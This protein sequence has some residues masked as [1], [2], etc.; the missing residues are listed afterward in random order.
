MIKA[1]YVVSRNGFERNLDQICTGRLARTFNCETAALVSIHDTNK[2][3][4]IEVGMTAELGDG[5]SKSLIVGFDDI[6]EIETG[7]KGPS[8]DLV[9]FIADFVD[10]I[11]SCEK[12]FLFIAQ[13]D[14][15]V[16]R[17]G[18]VGEYVCKRSGLDGAD[19]MH[20][21]PKVAHNP[22]MRQYF[23]EILA[24]SGQRV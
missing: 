10:E 2:P 15:G 12:E 17:S 5:L 1:I 22:L 21:N 4:V 11:D 9:K 13:C 8:K 19:T 20:L 14:T 3:P 6:T 23:E 16:S 24:E 18:A 7:R